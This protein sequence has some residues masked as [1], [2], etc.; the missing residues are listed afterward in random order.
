MRKPLIAGNWKMNN[1]IDESK[2]LVNTIKAGVHQIT[3][4]DIL[5]CPPFTA[6]QAVADCLER[7]NVE[8]GAQNMYSAIS[9]AFTGEVSPSM[10]KDIGCRFVILGH[11][12]RRT[13]FKE[14]DAVVNEKVKLALQYNLVPIVCIGETLQERE[15]GAAKDVVK[16][17]MLG[18]LKDIGIDQIDSVVLAYEPVWAIGTGKTATPAQAEEVHRFIRQQ[19]KQ[20]YDASRAESVRI[21]YGGSMKPENVVDLM[22]QENIDGGLIGGAALKAESFIQMIAKTKELIDE[23]N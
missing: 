6:L 19:L 22:K 3:G 16:A 9:G 7:S 12:E 8:I 2:N 20:M 1:T 5:V 18:S 23:L 11:S 21:L 17:Q 13:I 4:V 14:T 15:K 10:I